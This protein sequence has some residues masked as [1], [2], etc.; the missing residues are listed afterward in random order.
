MVLL[1]T[2]PDIVL[3][4]PPFA[5]LSRSTRPRTFLQPAF[6]ESDLALEQSFALR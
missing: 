3:S 6:G 1:L 4:P 2:V 5:A